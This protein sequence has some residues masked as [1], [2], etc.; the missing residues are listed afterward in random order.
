MPEDR[1]IKVLKEIAH[2]HSTTYHYLQQYPGGMEGLKKD[3]PDMFLP[4]FNDL[5]GDNEDMKKMM[6]ESQSSFIKS[7]G[8]V[9][10]PAFSLIELSSYNIN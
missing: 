8:K 2:F 7:A 9:I 5:M 10:H 1:L 4:S 3:D 6:I